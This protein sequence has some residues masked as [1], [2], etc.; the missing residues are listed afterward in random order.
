MAPK[1]A[2]NELRRQ[3]V[4]SL[5]AQREV[6]A[7]HR[8][9]DPL[10]LL[11]LREAAAA[12]PGGDRA[13]DGPASLHVL[14]RTQGQLEAALA[15]RRA[16]GG[17][18][19]GMVYVDFRDAGETR[20]AVERCREESAP[21]GLATRRIL[22]V[23]E[24]SALRALV[25]AGPDAVLARNLGSLTLCRQ[26]APGVPVVADGSL[27]VA[28]ALSGAVVVGWGAVRVTA[29][30][31][32]GAERAEGLASGLPAGRLEVVVYG[33]EALFHMEHCLFAS[34]LSGGRDRRTC[35]QPCRGHTLAL[36]D[37]RGSEFVVCADGGCRNT[38]FA[39]TARNDI[40]GTSRLAGCG[41]RDFRVEL[42]DETAEAS[43]EVLRKVSEALAS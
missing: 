21:V 34:R 2:L 13:S 6:A 18:G 32:L 10:A 26:W 31:D 40:E 8:V 29:A 41:V 42:V 11:R 14:V 35:G 36:S 28:N 38:I 17:N 19:A 39:A 25:E 23:G 15:W 30:A 27:N 7:A 22:R 16:S 37:R 3:I 43:G 1:S 12:A 4:E 20:R 24:E 5:M 33:R 9:A